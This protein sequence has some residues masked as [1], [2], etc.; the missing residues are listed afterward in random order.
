M[1]RT[2]AERGF[3]REYWFVCTILAKQSYR[4]IKSP[5]TDTCDRAPTKAPQ[6][7]VVGFHLVV[8]SELRSLHSLMHHDD[9]KVS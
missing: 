8:I 1:L 5:M 3:P 4:D 6:E 2:A 9:E 7:H